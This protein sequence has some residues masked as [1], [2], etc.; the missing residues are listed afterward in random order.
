MTLVEQLKPS[1]LMAIP[2]G[3]YDQEVGGV[4]GLHYRS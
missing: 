1:G 2:V 4:S 3:K